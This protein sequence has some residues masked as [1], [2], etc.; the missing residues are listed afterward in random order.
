MTF[1]PWLAQR[2]A[3]EYM[4]DAVR[5]AQQAQLARAGMSVSSTPAMAATSRRCPRFAKSRPQ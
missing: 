1:N 4:K 3:Q 2:M 5:K